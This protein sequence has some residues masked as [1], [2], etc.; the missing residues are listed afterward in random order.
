MNPENRQNSTKRFFRLILPALFFFIVAAVLMMSVLVSCR[1]R[2]PYLDCRELKVPEGMKCIPGGF[3]IRGSN[4]TTVDED[5]HRKVQDESPEMRIE[6]STFFMDTYEVTY[7]EY[8]ECVKAGG[9]PPVEPN[10]RNGYRNPKQPMLGVNWYHA[11]DYCKWRGKRLPTEAEWEK[12]ARGDNGELYPWG[13]AEADCTRAIIQEKGVKGCGT[14]K[15]W[16][17]GRALRQYG[18]MTWQ[19]FLGMG[20]GLVQRELWRVRKAV[21]EKTRKAPAMEGDRCRSI[22]KRSSAAGH[23]GGMRC[24]HSDRTEGLI[25]RQIIRITISDSGA[26]GLRKQNNSKICI[27]ADIMSLPEPVFMVAF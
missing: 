12:A 23:G 10:Y 22:R 3:F 9:C 17:V 1:E 21:R 15:T 20:A 26:P 27:F 16:D 11:R 14:G 2:S 13:N 8:Q 19:E 6:L 7:S 5:S 18:F 24:T 4:R 25:I